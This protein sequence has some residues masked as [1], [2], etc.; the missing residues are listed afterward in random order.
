MQSRGRSGALIVKIARHDNGFRGMRNRWLVFHILDQRSDICARH[1][2]YRPRCATDECAGTPI[3]ST[4]KPS[5]RRI[6]QF[7]RLSQPIRVCEPCPALV[8]KQK[9][10]A[11]AHSPFPLVREMDLVHDG[12]R[13]VHQFQVFAAIAKRSDPATH[14][15]PRKAGMRRLK[16]ADICCDHEI[17]TWSNRWRQRNRKIHTLGKSPS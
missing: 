13:Q 10:P 4:I 3:L 15:L 9:G 7:K 1:R 5:Q 8:R 16:H 14:Q 17:P 2:V 11:S 6:S 12:P